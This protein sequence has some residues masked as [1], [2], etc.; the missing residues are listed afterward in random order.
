MFEKSDIHTERD[1]E[2]LKKLLKEHV[3]N[4]NKIVTQES[5]ESTKKYVQQKTRTLVDDLASVMKE[6]PRAID[7][8]ITDGK[9][10]HRKAINDFLEKMR[11]E[12][13]H[14]RED[15]GWT[16][17]ELVLEYK[18][19]G[20]NSSEVRF[21]YNT[22]PIT[23]YR[24]YSKWEDIQKHYEQIKSQFELM[25]L[26]D[27][28]LI[29]AFWEAYTKL[30]Q[31]TSTHHLLTEFYISLWETFIRRQMKSRTKK[32]TRFLEFPF[33]AFTYNVDKYKTLLAEHP[34]IPAGRKL[35]TISGNQAANRDHAFTFGALLNHRQR[36]CYVELSR[37]KNM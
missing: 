29:D 35:V 13:R 37:D 1:Y 21:T 19:P 31:T 28:E 7:Q 20:D 16:I 32:I 14:V 8:A 10:K 36:F 9:A 27:S 12:G 6:L 34:D 33:W 25:T 22:Y 24:L 11:Q 2:S 4:I 17:D 30:P 26:P 18:H 5:P 15:Q 3:Q 23:T